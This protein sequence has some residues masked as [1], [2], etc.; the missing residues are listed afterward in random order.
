MGCSTI[1]DKETTVKMRSDPETRLSVVAHSWEA[2]H[3]PRVCLYDQRVVPTLTP[4]PLG[5]CTRETRPPNIW[6]QKPMGL[7]SRVGCG[8]DIFMKVFRCGLTGSRT[9]T[10]ASLQSDWIVS[11]RDVAACL[12][13]GQITWD[14][15]LL[16]FCTW[17]HLAAA[18]GRAH[19]LSRAKSLPH[20]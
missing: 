6:L 13:E 19:H 2:S 18:R 14:F 16:S 1:R 15:F 7:T 3:E 11:D 10:E 17:P 8:S 4:Q 5:T 9:S 20:P 12:L